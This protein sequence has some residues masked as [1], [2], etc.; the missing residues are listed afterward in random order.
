MEWHCSCLETFLVRHEAAPHFLV[1]GCGSQQAFLS[2]QAFLCSGGRYLRPRNLKTSSSEVAWK[3]LF[4]KGQ[5]HL[6]A[7]AQAMLL[8]T[9]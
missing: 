1:G 2:F 8:C 3:T 7:G 5:E 4:C 9:V 6:V